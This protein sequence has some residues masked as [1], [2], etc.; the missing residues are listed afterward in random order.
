MQTWKDLEKAHNFCQNENTATLIFRPQQQTDVT[1]WSKRWMTSNQVLSPCA[2]LFNKRLLWEFEIRKYFHHRF[3]W[4]SICLLKISFLRQYPLQNDSVSGGPGS[5]DRV[6]RSNSE[7]LDSLDLLI[8]WASWP[9][10]M[11]WLVSAP[12]LFFRC[13]HF[14]CITSLSTLHHLGAIK[15]T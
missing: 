9:G 6:K 13:L 1:L 12:D 11:F 14:R 8:H 7:S 10:W 3:I 15:Q 4:G 5:R 2:S